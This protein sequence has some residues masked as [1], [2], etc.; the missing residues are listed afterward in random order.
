MTSNSKPL[1]ESVATTSYDPRGKIRVCLFEN[2]CEV[3]VLYVGDEAE[4]ERIMDGWK[5]GTY[6]VL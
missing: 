3:A 4:A 5:D 2:D 1:R 6:R